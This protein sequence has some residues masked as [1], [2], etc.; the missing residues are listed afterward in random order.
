MFNILKKITKTH[1]K[2]NIRDIGE[3]LVYLIENPK[4][5]I[6]IVRNDRSSE[7]YYTA[8]DYLA[9]KDDQLII[10]DSYNGF[11]WSWLGRYARLSK[12]LNEHIGVSYY[13]SIPE[14]EEILKEIRRLKDKL[15]GG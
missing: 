2:P 15:R 4:H 14:E 6:R 8:V 1:N 3:A 5:E 13:V 12:S 10:K 11:K 7:G 9:I